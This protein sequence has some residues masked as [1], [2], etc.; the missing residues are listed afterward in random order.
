MSNRIRRAGFRY[1]EEDTYRGLVTEVSVLGDTGYGVCGRCRLTGAPGERFVFFEG[2]M[3]HWCCAGELLPGEERR[4]WFAGSRCEPPSQQAPAGWFEVE[5]ILRRWELDEVLLVRATARNLF[6][7]CPVRK[8]NTAGVAE[9]LLRVVSPRTME[10]ELLRLRA[11][12]TLLRIRAEQQR[13]ER[14]P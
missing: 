10:R 14:N 9:P 12:E 5:R 1:A 2:G 6:A 3:A 4:A 7:V 11:D 13:A 8:Q